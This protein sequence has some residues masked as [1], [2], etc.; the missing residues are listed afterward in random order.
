MARKYAENTTVTVERSKAEIERLLRAH[1]ATGLLMAWDEDEGKS[2]VQFRIEGRVVKMVV[3]DPDIA[4][5]SVSDAGR[6][7][8]PGAARTAVDKELRRR[9]RALLLITKAKLEMVE[10][11]ESSVDR[12]FMADILL[13]DG[14]TVG[15]KMLPKLVL[16]YD[17]GKMPRQLLPGGL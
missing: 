14:S 16:A 11:G 4:E 15:E 13:P 7:R 1:D 12:E 2:V 5:Y 9:W 8:P 10:S 6:R 3:T 17:T